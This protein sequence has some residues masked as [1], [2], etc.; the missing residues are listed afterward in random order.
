MI[1][2][3]PSMRSVRRSL[4][5]A[6]AIVAVAA[7]ATA[8]PATSA[9]AAGSVTATFTKTSDWGTGYEAKYTI[10][11]GTSTATSGWNLQFTLAAGQT[12][13][14]VW[15]DPYTFAS[16]HVSITNA[17]WDGVINPGAS[18]NV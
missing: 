3:V 2:E 17:S 6:A 4:A 5:G 11:N 1:L 8:L 12:V 13:S 7:F 16:Q 9:Y 18:L 10:T 15:S 14:S